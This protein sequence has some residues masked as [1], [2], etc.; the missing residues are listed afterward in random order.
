MASLV[1]GSMVG[2]AKNAKLGLIRLK[3]NNARY[4]PISATMLAFD[5]ILAHSTQVNSRGRSVV[6]MAFSAPVQLLWWPAPTRTPRIGGLIDGTDVFGL[7]LKDLYAAGIAA[8]KS[9]GNYADHDGD[10]TDLSFGTPGRNGGTNTPLIVAGN[11]EINNIRYKT[12]QIVDS[13]NKGILSLYAVGV[14][15]I[16]A[17]YD[18]TSPNTA[19]SQNTFKVLEDSGMLDENGSSQASA[20]TTGVIANLLGDPTIRASLVAGGLPNF[21]AAVKKFVLDMSGTNK[22]TF[23]DGIPRLSN[24]FSIPCPGPGVNGR[25]IP[26]VETRPAS[27]VKGLTPVFREVANGPVVTFANLVRH[28]SCF[29]HSFNSFP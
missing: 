28:L 2:A 18:D 29:G 22:G 14:E 20:I 11:N 5:T 27:P 24:G 12:S 16:A 4:S 23:P 7:K 13:S 6:G 15:D 19:A 21:A 26:P 8:V 17:V 9:A 25:P 1:A 10:V 3:S